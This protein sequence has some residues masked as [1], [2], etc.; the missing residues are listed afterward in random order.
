MPY[1]Y[2]N[3]AVSKLLTTINSAATTVVVASG[4]GA[5]F[6]SPVGGDIAWITLEE[7]S[8]LEV[9]ACTARSGDSLT[10]IRGQQG[11]TAVGFNGGDTCKVEQRPTQYDL[12]RPFPSLRN[13]AVPLYVEF[14]TNDEDQQLNQVV[15]STGLVSAVASEAG[16]PGIAELTTQGNA[17][18]CFGYMSGVDSVYIGDGEMDFETE[19]RVTTLSDGTNRF[20]IRV[21][22]FDV[23][24]SATKPVDGVYVEYRDADS[25][26]FRA[27]TS[28]NSTRTEN[29]SSTTVAAATW[30][31]IHIN[32]NAAGTSARF[33]VNDVLIDTITTNIPTGAGR[34]T[35]LGVAIMKELGTTNR[36]VRCDYIAFN[37]QLTTTR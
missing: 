5:R 16:H 25:A 22:F 34:E 21:G 31:R 26:N 12:E 18:G 7:G 8:N 9:V 10:V 23:V 11:T 4:H 14:N 28:S 30:Y 20:A 35:R 6:P 2:A 33:W 17:G 32:I 37:K 1:V 27:C 24:A 29:N 3:G 13:N 19:I 36:Q 15:V